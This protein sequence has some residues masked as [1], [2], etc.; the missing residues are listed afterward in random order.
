MRLVSRWGGE[1][2]I[3]FFQEDFFLSAEDLFFIAVGWG[4]VLQAK[5]M[6]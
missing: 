3:F 4:G 1:K 6:G 2:S 5:K